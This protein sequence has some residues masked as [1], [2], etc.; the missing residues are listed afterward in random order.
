MGILSDEFESMYGEGEFYL[1]NSL[2]AWCLR[3]GKRGQQILEEWNVEK[4]VTFN[5]FEITPKDVCYGSDKLVWWKC[6]RCGNEYQL[7]IKRR[8]EYIVGCKKCRTKG[9]SYSEMVIY[10]GIKEKFPK[11]ISRCKCGD[12]ELEFDIVIPE[13]NVYIE[14]SGEYWH[15]QFSNNDEKKREYCKLNNIRFI[16]IMEMKK[17][18]DMVVEENLI[19]YKYSE[20]KQDVMLYQI[21]LEIY[22][23]LGITE[24][25]VDYNKVLANAIDRM[26]RPVEN[27]LVEKYP[28]I[29]EEWDNELNNGALPEYYTVSSSKRIN[30]KCR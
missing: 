6:P 19:K 14:Y 2:Y 22:K 16:E 5:G 26:M 27:S 24:L 3:N 10:Y 28:Q 15:S 30:W 21:L 12:E 20:S 11:A 23:M 4:N 1:E 29:I 7:P 9:Q 8:I 17:A 25:D 13:I 18:C